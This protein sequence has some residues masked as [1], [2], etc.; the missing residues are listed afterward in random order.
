MMKKLGRVALLAGCFMGAAAAQDD[1]PVAVN[2]QP[3]FTVIPGKPNQIPENS[4]SALVTWNGS[5]TYASK[6][7]VFTMVGTAPAKG[8]STT[9][10]AILIPLNIVVQH[11]GKGVSFSP[12]HV[13]P[14]GRTVTHNTVLSPIFDK[15]TTYTLGGVDVG[16]TQYLDA[17]QR[18]NFWEW[19]KTNTGY[20]VLLGGPT[21]EPVQ[22][23]KV[24]AADGSEAIAFGVTVAL[25]DINWFDSAIQALITKYSTPNQIP[26][27]LTY[28]TYLT[29]NSQCCIGGYHSFNGTNT[30]MTATYVDKSGA[31]SQDVSALSHEIGEWVDDPYVNNSVSCGILEI[32]DPEEGFSNYGDFPYTVNGFSY[33]LQDMVYLDYFGAAKSGRVNGWLTFHDNPFGLGVCSNGG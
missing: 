5:F 13:L 21:V 18:A 8:P 24:P 33:N 11:G 23:L 22:T 25:V 32:G 2:P 4:A 1:V 30:Y 28:D 19:V 15:T 6:K 27:F 26:I 10:R 16:T 29:Q 14:D 31:F 17:F 7:Y 9:V 20:H 3:M 12:T